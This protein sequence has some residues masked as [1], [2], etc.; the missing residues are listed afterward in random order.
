MTSLSASTA[1]TR[2]R[3]RPSTSPSPP[4][5]RGACAAVRHAGSGD[6]F[7]ANGSPRM[8]FS[9]VCLSRCVW[10]APAGG[11]ASLSWCQSVGLHR[12]TII[13]TTDPK[14]KHTATRTEPAHKDGRRSALPRLPAAP[15]GPR[16]A[17]ALLPA[18][19]ARPALAALRRP[20]G[21]ARSAASETPRSAIFVIRLGADDL[22]GP[23]TGRSCAGALLCGGAGGQERLPSRSAPQQQ[24]RVRRVRW[25]LLHTFGAA[26]LARAAT[27]H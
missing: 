22:P 15:V 20:R 2:G 18:A 7:I 14:S 25:W 24:P 6:V 19:R 27:N 4:P 1:T 3:H 12:S 5:A 8:S 23:H 9:L 16:I 17:I 10:C 11:R 13:Q 21:A 26:R